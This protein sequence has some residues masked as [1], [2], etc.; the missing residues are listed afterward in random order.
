V[1]P[2]WLGQWFIS[3]PPHRTSR[4]YVSGP[5]RWRHLAVDAAM[6]EME[7]K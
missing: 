6:K 7:L 4:G 5:Y 3:L 1:R 2:S